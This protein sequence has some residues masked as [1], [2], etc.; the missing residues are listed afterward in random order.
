M[1]GIEIIGKSGILL[2]AHILLNMFLINYGL[3]YTFIHGHV[4]IYAYPQS[5]ACLVLL[6]CKSYNRILVTPKP[7]HQQRIYC[8]QYPTGPTPGR[9]LFTEFKL[10]AGVA[11]GLNIYDCLLCRAL[12]LS[13]GNP[14]SFV[15]AFRILGMKIRR[16]M[17]LRM[18]MIC[19][20]Q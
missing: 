10:L 12:M 2:S 3:I 20:Q 14:M 18:V 5:R 7:A 9:W 8:S 15:M 13:I 11:F 16:C 4:I 17:M 1:T 6:T 19:Y